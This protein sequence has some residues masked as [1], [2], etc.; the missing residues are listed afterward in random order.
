MSE[1]LYRNNSSDDDFLPKKELMRA[2]CSQD[3]QKSIEVKDR[4]DYS[5][6]VECPYTYHKGKLVCISCFFE[7][8]KSDPTIED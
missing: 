3:I 7:L 2:W 1:S 8:E 6:T 5:V 4:H